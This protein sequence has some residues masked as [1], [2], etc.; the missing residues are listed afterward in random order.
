MFQYITFVRIGR[1]L[2]NHQIKFSA[3]SERNDFAHLI[4]QVK[5]SDTKAD[6]RALNEAKKPNLSAIQTKL[7]APKRKRVFKSLETKVLQNVSKENKLI[8]KKLRS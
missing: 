8:L 1:C 5:P 4:Y 7:H 2:C 3:N 6:E